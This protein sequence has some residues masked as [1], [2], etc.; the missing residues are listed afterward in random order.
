MKNQFE[1]E[2]ILKL[3]RKNHAADVPRAFSKLILLLGFLSHGNSFQNGLKKFHTKNSFPGRGC[4]GARAINSKI[5]NY[6]RVI[7]YLLFILIYYFI[8]ITIYLLFIILFIVYF[9][10]YYSYY[11]IYYLLFFIYLII[12]ILFYLLLFYLFT[13]ILIVF[14]LFYL[15]LLLFNC[16]FCIL[17]API[18]CRRLFQPAMRLS[19]YSTYFL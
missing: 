3:K 9:I 1:K 18:F 16:F 17:K 4:A 2:G 8:I 14:I 7:Y 10:Y 5:I 15:F 13:I 11:F 12:I 19:T 6:F